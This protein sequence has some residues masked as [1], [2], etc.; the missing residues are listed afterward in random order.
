MPVSKLRTGFR[1][2]GVSYTKKEWATMMRLMD[3]DHSLSI[4]E[5]EF[6]AVLQPNMGHWRDNRKSKKKKWRHAHKM[7]VAGSPALFMPDIARRKNLSE[8]D[9]GDQDVEAG[10]ESAERL[11]LIPEQAPRVARLL[12]SAAGTKAAAVTNTAAGMASALRATT[13]AKE[14][15]TRTGF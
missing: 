15:V 11:S 14:K 10:V 5:A 12:T 2:I 8:R 13:A 7:L 6:V 3:R 1:S 4:T 9:K